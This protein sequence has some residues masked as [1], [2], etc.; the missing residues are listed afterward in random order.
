MSLV[1]WDPFRDLEDMNNRMNAMF[2][3]A[4]APFGARTQGLVASTEWSPSVDISETPQEFH[5]KVELPEV[6]RE[7]VK[8]SVTEGVLRVSGERKQEK[9]EKGVKY[10]RTERFYGSFMRAFTLPDNVDA[11]RISATFKD[12][13]L[14]VGLPKIERPAPKATEIKIT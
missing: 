8:L 3:G 13:V 2:G 7:D 12:G 1:R 5:I 9:E 4:M 14:N 11:T 6:K 10:H